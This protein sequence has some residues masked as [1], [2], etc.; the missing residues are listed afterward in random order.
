MDAQETGGKYN[1]IVGSNIMEEQGIDIF[2]S[3]HFIVRD[4]VCVLLKLQGDLSD[5]RYCEQLFN[6]HTDSS[7]FQQMKE[8]THS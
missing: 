4:S 2:Y 7:I 1:T 8:R 5:K 3:D 6:I